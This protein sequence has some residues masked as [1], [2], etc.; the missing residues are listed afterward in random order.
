MNF[1]N[2]KVSTR[3]A[4]GFALMIVLMVIAIFLG[5]NRMAM[6]Q[7]RINQIAQVNN[8]QVAQLMAMRAS[9][10]DRMIAVRNV[11][12][13]QTE[14]EMRPEIERI[15]EG[16]KKFA[17]ADEKLSKLFEHPST[18][19]QERSL[20]A[21]IHDD[22]AAILAPMTRAID[23]GLQNKTAEA[24]R[25]L[26]EEVR[27]VQ[28]KL[29][30]ELGEL[31]VLEERLSQEA[32]AAGVIAYE[33]AKTQMLL[34]GLFALVLGGLSA[35][36]ITRSIT[37]QLGGEPQ[38][39]VDVATRIAAGDLDVQIDTAAGDSSSLMAAMKSMRDKL[40]DIVRNVRN[41]TDTIATASSQIAAGNLDLSSRTEEQASS[42]EE[43]ASSMEELTSTVRQ[44][45]ENAGQANQLAI[46]ASEV[47]ARGG[48]V[49]SE[50]VDT[51]EQI[52]SSARK[53]V[54]IIG[55]IDGIAFQTNILA[56]N[57]AVE[58]A[59]AGE[60]GRGFAV[61][62]TEVRSL[63]QRSAA[64]AKEIKSL[65][66]DS[67]DKVENGSKLVAEAGSTMDEVVSSVRRVTDIMAEITAAS[68]EQS[69]GIEQVNQAI[70]Q[71]DQVT[72]QNAAL[73]EE[74]AAAADSLQEQA[75]ALSEIVSV[76]RVS[77]MSA[78]GGAA[79]TRLAAKKPAKVVNL[80]AR[81]PRAVASASAAPVPARK[82][83][84]GGGADEWEEF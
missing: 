53:I 52:N 68:H 27:P 75:A 61:V 81:A 71:M 49:V 5:L 76:F 10:F 77:G 43:T 12:L 24:T 28:R 64:A 13:L 79:K 54:D 78:G 21:R 1:G 23:L 19:E 48:S 20:L 60:Q 69:A 17:T 2:A 6:M 66:G 14:Q 82:V 39:A 37:K 9:V 70:T 25:V 32:S 46:N 38:T 59:R 15:R 4:G 55:V 3:L 80:P 26:I 35:W 45:A 67:V 30:G 41:G 47:A 50:V 74:A 56:L 40:A 29:M 72:Q 33:S 31:A 16:E 73:V 57:A 8:A 63:A 62:A 18:T 42:L 7:D 11:V 51:M 44:N 34:L 22:H 58:A 36:M 83:A 65:I 84:A